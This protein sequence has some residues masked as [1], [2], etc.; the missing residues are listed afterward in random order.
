MGKQFIIERKIHTVDAQEAALGRLAC[1]IAKLLIGKHKI[2][3]SPHIDNGDIVYVKN[4]DNLKVTGKKLEHKVY[5]H[6]SLYP[7]G[8][9]AKRMSDL[10][11]NNKFEILRRAVFSMLPKTRHRKNM[12]K[13][14]RIKE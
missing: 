4:I 6:H 9:R 12:I 5:Y 14:L 8:L 2:K 11:K 10:Y 7:G 13:R 1:G 3:Y